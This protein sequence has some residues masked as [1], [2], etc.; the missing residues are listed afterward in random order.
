MHH[1]NI[2][3]KVVSSVVG[4]HLKGI[5]TKVIHQYFDSDT[6]MSTQERSPFN[7]LPDLYEVKWETGEVSNNSAWNLDPA[8]IEP[9]ELLKELV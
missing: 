2:G 8:P 5:V 6:G 4:I 1:F 9:N 3:D 7:R